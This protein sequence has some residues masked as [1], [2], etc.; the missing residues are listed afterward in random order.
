MITLLS[1][2]SVFFPLQWQNIL[3]ASFIHIAIL[4]YQTLKYIYSEL[5]LFLYQRQKLQ[6]LQMALAS[7]RHV[8]RVDPP[9]FSGPD[10]PNGY[11][12][13]FI[14]AE[15]VSEIYKDFVSCRK[16]ESDQLCRSFKGIS[17]VEGN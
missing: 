12:A 13:S 9:V 15:Q 6:Y 11:S 16:E 1:F 8:F 10:D 3:N 14:T 17:I 5:H 4:L 2:A 7:Q